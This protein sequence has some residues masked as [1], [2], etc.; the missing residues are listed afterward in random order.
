[1]VP[2]ALVGNHW[3]RV[4]P[5]SELT[6]GPICSGY[7]NPYPF[8]QRY[9]ASFPLDGDVFF[10]QCDFELLHSSLYVEIKIHPPN[11]ICPYWD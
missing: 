9:F 7:K 6:E 5:M 1:M 10:F 2:G 4:S 8:A 3:C 11:M